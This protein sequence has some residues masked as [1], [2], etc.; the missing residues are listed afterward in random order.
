MRKYYIANKVQTK[1][2]AM[3]SSSKLYICDTLDDIHKW[4]I[5]D[6]AE[7]MIISLPKEITR[8][9]NVWKVYTIEDS[10]G[11]NKVIKQESMTNYKCYN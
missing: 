7:N 1:F 5:R 4:T 3:D 10:D 9:C 8:K 11:T 6:K 2:I